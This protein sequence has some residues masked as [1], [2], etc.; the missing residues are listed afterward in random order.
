MKCC[1]DRWNCVARCRKYQWGTRGWDLIRHSP[2]L[3]LKAMP[4]GEAVQVMVNINDMKDPGNTG[5]SD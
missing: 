3:S 5:A 1:Q 2:G 4:A